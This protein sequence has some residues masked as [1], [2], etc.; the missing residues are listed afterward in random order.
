MPL[1]M[2][3]GKLLVD[4]DGKPLECD[5][6][7]C[8]GCSCACGADEFTVPD[9]T[10]GSGL[11]ISFMATDILAS[12]PNFSCVSGVCV[13]TGFITSTYNDGSNDY[14][15]NIEASFQL[16]ADGTWSLSIVGQSEY[17]HPGSFPVGEFSY[18][19]SGSMGEGCT[20]IAIGPEGVY[21][22]QGA[23]AIGPFDLTIGFAP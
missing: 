13:W 12:N 9:I 14:A 19:R 23:G 11:F 4:G 17:L 8:G 5:D 20:P 7:P 2:R 10:V 15:E 21:F 18:T 16:N 1:W 6:C 22:D 3:D